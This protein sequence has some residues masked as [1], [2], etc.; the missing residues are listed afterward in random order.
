MEQEIRRNIPRD[1]FLHLLAVVTL[2]WSAVSFVTILWQ[3][4][5]DTPIGPWWM[6]EDLNLRRTQGPS[7]LQPDAIDRSATH[8][9]S[10]HQ[11]DTR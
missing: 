6:G 10:K 9:C 11:F 7:G 3:S 5:P 1:L 4:H 2:Y 8:P